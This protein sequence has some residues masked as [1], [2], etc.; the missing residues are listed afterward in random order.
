MSG[1]RSVTRGL[2]SIGNKMLAALVAVAVLPTVTVAVYAMREASAALVDHALFRLND[3]TTF[4][5][6]LAQ[7]TLR[8]LNDVVLPEVVAYQPLVRVCSTRLPR[9]DAP[10]VSA[11]EQEL[12]NLLND[13]T[14]LERKLSQILDRNQSCSTIQVLQISAKPQLV[15]RIERAQS[16]HEI[17]RTLDVDPA[18]QRLR[19]RAEL[20]KSRSVDVKI[21]LALRKAVQE[22]PDR[23]IQ[24][25]T[26]PAGPGS[27][28]ALELFAARV[29]NA[30]KQLV[31]YVIVGLSWS[32]ILQDMVQEIAAPRSEAPDSF[33]V[34]LFDRE[35]EPVESFPVNLP[36]E[37]PPSLKARATAGDTESALTEEGELVA[38][39]PVV[40][41]EDEARDFLVLALSRSREHL[42]HVDRF[43]YVFSA[44]L[45]GALVL[46]LALGTYLSRRLTRPLKQLRDSARVIGSGD[47]DLEVRVDTADEVE[48]VSAEFNAMTQK[49]KSLY[50]S[51]EDTIRERTR[52]LQKALDDLRTAHQNLLDSEAR[53]SDIVENASDL[54]QVT[55]ESGKIL[56]V[57]RR[58]L[59]LVGQNATEIVGRDFLE[60]VAPP[61]REAT[62][63][64][65]QTVL[66]GATLS[67]FSSQ[68]LADNG[69]RTVPIEIS[70][71]PV[72]RDGAVRG[73]RAILR[74][75]SE[76]KLFESQMIKAE[77]L[78][79]VGAL[80]AGV[81][82]EINN[83]LSIITMFAQ[84][85][86]EKARK[87]EVDVDK[88]EKILEQ[89]RRVATITRGLLDFS[90]LGPT[91]FRKFDLERTLRDTVALVKE[92]ALRNSIELKVSLGGPLPLLVGNP[93]QIEQVLLN[94]LLNAMYA[95]G[96]DGSIE[97]R[98]K[99]VDESRLPGKRPAVRVSVADSGLGIK[100]D[101]LP[102]LFEPFF[103]TKS[104]GEGTGLGLSVSYGIIKDHQGAIWA[105]NREEGG[106]EFYFDL[107]LSKEGMK[108]SL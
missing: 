50:A 22:H 75:V 100:E 35:L 42:R 78:S 43:R 73:V 92:R 80:A 14:L 5:A 24:R 59:Q 91:E 10:E 77:R 69:R 25:V 13:L 88:V 54:I 72:F 23:L 62:H 30:Q 26:L 96:R 106:A 16:R 103:T 3:N 8:V 34:T 70:A 9:P 99:E 53:Y 45:I 21:Q 1:A 71:T 15:L 94:L 48:E 101:S 44:V 33:R 86:L 108:T 64:A 39:A 17:G 32:Q 18:G 41:R 105:E 63:G 37:L 87:G 82:H 27:G 93:Q 6:R 11:P 12:L 57:N 55:D 31:A 89:A 84:R 65:F 51:L 104:P 85:A 102:H 58:Q 61:L 107:P 76:R 29:R 79:S 68:L 56:S 97:V 19:L 2:N 67:A 98:A 46:A 20:P 47:L 36:F 52:Q 90:R 66:S 28:D 7:D 4:G 49:L 40:P 60:L 74:D 38:F 83:P 81:A 95:V